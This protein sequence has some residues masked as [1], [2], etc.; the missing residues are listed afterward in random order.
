MWDM[1]TSFFDFGDLAGLGPGGSIPS[2]PSQFF[3]FENNPDNFGSAAD[4]TANFVN[5]PYAMESLTG[6]Y[7]ADFAATSYIDYGNQ[8]LPDTFSFVFVIKPF[9]IPAGEFIL[10]TNR[11][12]GGTD[13]GFTLALDLTSTNPVVSFKTGNGAGSGVATATSGIADTSNWGIYGVVV[14]TIL[15]EVKIYHNGTDLTLNTPSYV[16]DFARTGV[17][18][19]GQ[20]STNSVNSE[21]MQ[22][23]EFQFFDYALSGAEALAITAN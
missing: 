8:T 11:G 21:N 13:N 3:A 14:D 7:S 4:W 18:Y 12:T 17:L 6:T 5:T 15:Q 19:M 16:W 2:G 22:I 23:D 9:S 10:L 1:A 20:D